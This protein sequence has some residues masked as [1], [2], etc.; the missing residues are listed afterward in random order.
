MDFWT[1]LGGLTMGAAAA[2]IYDMSSSPKM[3]GDR[4]ED[5]C[6]EEE[7]PAGGSPGG[8]SASVGPS[9]G[10]AS[11]GSVG[12]FSGP[13]SGGATGGG[14]MAPPIGGGG[15]F[16][17]SPRNLPTVSVPPQ[18]TPPGS[19]G[20]SFFGV[21]AP[22]WFWPLNYW[23]YPYPQN[24]AYVCKKTTTEEGEDRFECQPKYPIRNAQYTYGPP[25]GW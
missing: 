2:A 23:P 3:M 17:T 5:D 18:V 20:E 25:W 14:S 10:G 6:E 15:G 8:V 24:P 9:G 12:V 1:F 7:D 13:P 16:T 11:F 4:C 22:P 19:F 21:S